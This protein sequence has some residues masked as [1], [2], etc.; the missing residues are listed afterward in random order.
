MG[1]A[2]V[3]QFG[4]EAELHGKRT[5]GKVAAFLGGTIVRR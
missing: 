1:Y 5:S 2:V 3:S 4:A